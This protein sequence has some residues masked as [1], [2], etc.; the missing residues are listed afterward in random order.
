MATSCTEARALSRHSSAIATMIGPVLTGRGFGGIA[1][2]FLVMLGDL[3]DRAG[4]LETEECGLDLIL[5][6]STFV[7]FLGRGLAVV[8]VC[9]G[10]GLIV[11]G[12]G[13]FTWMVSWIVSFCFGCSGA[14]C[15]GAAG[16]GVLEDELCALPMGI[17][18]GSGGGGAWRM[19]NGFTK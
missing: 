10:D 9:T 16:A 12:I 4:E 14:D 18:G 5:G 3:V 7:S 15:S 11:P 1:G 19:S 6:G 17:G 2:D 8:G 13:G